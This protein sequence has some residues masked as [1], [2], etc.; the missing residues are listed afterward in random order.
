MLRRRWACLRGAYT[1]RGGLIGGEI[2]YLNS[3]LWQRSRDLPRMY[4]LWQTVLLYRCKKH[5]RISQMTY[6]PKSIFGKMGDFEALILCISLNSSQIC[7]CFA[8]A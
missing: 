8:R 1:R 4:Y 6:Q 5:R 3:S 7:T 2:R